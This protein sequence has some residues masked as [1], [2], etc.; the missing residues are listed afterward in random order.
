MHALLSSSFL[1]AS[2]FF[3]LE[4]DIGQD[5]LRLQGSKEYLQHLHLDTEITINTTGLKLPKQLSF[6][7]QQ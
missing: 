4:K 3:L 1:L 2:N 6:L 7:Q 5:G